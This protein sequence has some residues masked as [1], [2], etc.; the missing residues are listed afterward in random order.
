MQADK[1]PTNAQVD[2]AVNIALGELDLQENQALWSLQTDTENLH[3]H[4]AV[5]MISPESY[6]VIKP[7]GGWTKKNLERAAREI[8]IIQGWEVDQNS[9]YEVNAGQIVEKHEAERHTWSFPD[10]PRHRSAH[11][12]WKPRTASEVRS[13][14]DIEDSRK[15]DVLHERLRTKGYELARRGN[16][17]FLKVRRP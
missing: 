14:E 17:A 3:V 6:R 4:A 7:S 9:R 1:S 12:K 5:N 13:S 8:E 10:R 16:G 11:R 2:E 15:L